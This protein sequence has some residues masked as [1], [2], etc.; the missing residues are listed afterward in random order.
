MRLPIDLTG[1]QAGQL[2][3]LLL[4]GDPDLLVLDAPVNGSPLLVIVARGD[5]RAVV[6][7]RLG[8]SAQEATGLQPE[9]AAEAPKPPKIVPVRDGVHDARPGGK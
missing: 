6:R 3:A 8:K 7:D 5:A 1:P 4:H 2:N 9:P